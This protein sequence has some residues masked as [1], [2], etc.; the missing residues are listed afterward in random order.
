VATD[1]H[2]LVKYERKDIKADLAIEFIVP[3]K[4]LNILKNILQDEESKTEILYNA[5]NAIFNFSNFKLVCRL[6]DGKYPNYDAVIP[7]D[8]P[9]VLEIDRNQ[10]LQAAKRSSI[11]SSKSTNQVRL[12]ITG[13]KLVIKAEDVDFNNKSEET[14]ECNY[15]GSDIAIGFNSKF[16]VEMLSNLES[17]SVKLELSSP[18]R[19]GIISPSDNDNDNEQIL[20]LVMP[21]M[22][23]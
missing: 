4:P 21:I 20:M 3:N 1:A 13:N 14:L 18:S 12:E 9:N 2:K 7:K 19:A 6:I 17:D 15:N 10:F 8:N 23:N 11:F 22:L 16:I 5:T